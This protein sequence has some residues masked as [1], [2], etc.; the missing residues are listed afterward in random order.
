MSPLLPKAQN[1][2]LISLD[3]HILNKEMSNLLKRFFTEQVFTQVFPKKNYRLW[4]K[5]ACLNLIDALSSCTVELTNLTWESYCMMMQHLSSKKFN[6]CSILPM[7]RRL[8]SRFYLYIPTVVD[9]LA[10]KEGISPYSEFF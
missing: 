9:N 3:C 8:L 4:E 5:H 2:I 6:A 1:E 10:V 7:S